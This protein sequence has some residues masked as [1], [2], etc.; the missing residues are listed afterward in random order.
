MMMQLAKKLISSVKQTFKNDKTDIH[1][2]ARDWEASQTLT[3]MQSESRAWKIAGVSTVLTAVSVTGLVMMLPFYKVVPMT[4][5]VDKA[6]GAAQLVD[7]STAKPMSSEQWDKHW[8]EEYVNS[9]ERYNWMLLQY[10]HDKTMAL[11]G[12]EIA[13]TYD[14]LYQGANSIDKQLGNYT[15]RRIHIVTSTLPPSNPGTAVVRFERSTRERGLDIEI[16]AEYIATLSYTYQKPTLRT[17]E[18]NIVANPSGFK[19]TGYVVD[20]VNKSTSPVE[21]SPTAPATSN[22]EVHAQ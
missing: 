9:R 20:K 13:K 7:T 2:Q 6:T 16:G 8:I 11:S 14:A 1:Q 17:L 3:L 12:D 22:S 19:V 18:K 15:E 21:A 4:F 10:D 5:L